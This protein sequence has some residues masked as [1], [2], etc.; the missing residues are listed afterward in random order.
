MRRT[1]QAG[2]EEDQH[3]GCASA[4]VR[5][6]TRQQSPVEVEVGAAVGGHVWISIEGRLANA[7]IAIGP[8]QADKRAAARTSRQTG[9]GREKL[10][11]IGALQK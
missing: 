10:E 2:R 5:G 4:R 8:K 6:T 7:G 11:R 3:I 1:E 9:S